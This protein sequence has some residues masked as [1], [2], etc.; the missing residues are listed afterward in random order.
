M[1]TGGGV[2]ADQFLKALEAHPSSAAVILFF[3]F[4]E[5]TAADEASL[6][7]R[8]IKMVVVSSFR[9]GYQQLIERGL[10]DL[11]IVPRNDALPP[12]GAAPITV[13]ERFDQQFSLVTAAKKEK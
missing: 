1:S 10:I 12:T 6:A 5:L 2:P 3:G 4:P 13:R 7:E 11:A 9:P 8:R